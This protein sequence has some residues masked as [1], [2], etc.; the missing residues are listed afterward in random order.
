MTTDDK[1]DR[2]LHLS[3]HDDIRA[4]FAAAVAAVE[5]SQA[6]EHALRKVDHTF[7]VDGAVLSIAGGVHVVAVGKAAVAMI[8]GAFRVLGDAIIS[9]DVITKDGH[10]DGELPARVRVSECGHP[11]PDERGVQA[12][13]KALEALREIP[14]GAVVLALI[15]GGGSALFEAPVEGVDLPDMARTTAL[16]LRAGPPTQALNA[17]KTPLSRV[18]G[19][20]LRLTAPEADWV[21]LI[22][23]DVLSNDPSLIASGPTLVKRADPAVALGVLEHYGVIDVAPVP[24][25]RALQH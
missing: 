16:L 22:L 17:A 2:V 21:T 13:M 12:T 7:Q 9:G 25:I 19:G 15:S 4:M 23:P 6:V 5:P 3:A 18:K 20:G 14:K 10:V 8:R 1:V 11:I 24:V